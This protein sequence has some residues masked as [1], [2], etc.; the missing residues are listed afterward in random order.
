MYQATPQAIKEAL[1]TFDLHLK[2]I[3][4]EKDSIRDYKEHFANWIRY[5]KAQLKKSTGSYAWKWKGQS[6]KRGTFAEL[7]VDRK[8]FDH[9]GFEFEIISNGN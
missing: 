8:S 6:V 9:P 1:Q 4:R 2:S 7:E 3:D 5:N